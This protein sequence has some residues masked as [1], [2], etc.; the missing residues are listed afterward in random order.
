M[1]V[2][3][4]PPPPPP[5]VVLR[6]R[7]TGGFVGRSVDGT[8][9]LGSGDARAAEAAAIVAALDRSTIRGGRTHPDMYSYE[10]DLGDGTAPVIVPEH[11][12]PDDLRRLAALLLD[13]SR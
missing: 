5:S 13:P 11:L 6:V 7:R 3:E 2:A 12:L 9:D 10:F 1:T 4:P 8:L